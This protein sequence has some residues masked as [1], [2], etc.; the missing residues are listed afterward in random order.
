MRAL[1]SDFR[2][3]CVGNI[4]MEYQK[5]YSNLNTLDF[6]G[7]FLLWTF[8]AMKQLTTDRIWQLITC[9]N[10]VS[11]KLSAEAVSFKCWQ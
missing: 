7:I 5:I 3:V 9:L 4:S 10:V 6:N 11:L 8:D 2:T 1:Q